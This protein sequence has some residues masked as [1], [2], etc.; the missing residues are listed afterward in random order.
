MI[1]GK[2]PLY[3]SDKAMIKACGFALTSGAKATFQLEKIDDV[4]VFRG[5][6]E[7]SNKHAGQLFKMFVTRDEQVYE[8][9]AWFLGW[10]QTQKA[11]KFTVALEFDT[12]VDFVNQLAAYKD[13]Y[14]TLVIY[15]IDGEGDLIDEQRRGDVEQVLK[16]GLVSIQCARACRDDDFRLWL[17][18]KY[19]AKATNEKEVAECIRR[20]LNIRSRAELDHQDSPRAKWKL[21]YQSYLRTLL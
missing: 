5:V 14:V 16:G 4:E 17:N 18:D 20:M 12:F 19:M 15:E 7:R 6:T 11:S 2:K 3:H 1:E 10:V 8:I 13:E 9:D 21:L